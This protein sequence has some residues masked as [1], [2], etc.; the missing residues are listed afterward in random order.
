[1]TTENI[2]YEI[3]ISYSRQD[4][5]LPANASTDATAWVTAL[6]DHILA[7]HRGFSTE[8]LRIFFDTDEIRNMDDWRHR[9]L[10][11]LRSSKILLVCLSPNYFASDYCRWEWEEYCRRQVHQLIGSDSIAG[12]YFVEVPGSAEYDYAAWLSSILRGN[13]TDIRPWFPEGTSALRREEVRRRMAAL[14]QSVWERLKRAR[15]AIAVPGNLR[16]QNPHFVGRREELRRLHEQLGTGA[17][18]VVT[19][20]HGLGGQGKTELAVAYAHG[21]ADHYPAGLWTLG[22]E[23]KKE[24]LPLIGELAAEPQ[25]GF[26]PSAAEK[27]DPALLGCGVLVHLQQRVEAVNA[28]DPDKG[29]AALLLLDNVSESALLSPAQLATLPRADW[30][31]L[32][33]T[34]RLGPETLRAH[35]SQLA[36]LAVDSLDEDSALALLRNH[37]PPRDAR[38][39]IVA[40]S[41]VGITG[42]ASRN[43]DNAAREIARALGGFT[44]AIEQV[45]VFL[46]LHPEIAPSAFLAGL[47]QKGLTSADRLVERDLDVGGQLLTQTKQLAIILE[48]TLSRLDVPALTALQFAAL[49]PPDS[50]SWPWLRALTIMRHPAVTDHAPDE[51]DPWLEIRRRLSGLRLLTPGDEPELARIHRLVAAHVRARED[52][53]MQD[54]LLSELRAFLR[55][56]IRGESASPAVDWEYPVLINPDEEMDFI[57][58]TII[59]RVSSNP[60]IN[61]WMADITV[62]YSIPDPPFDIWLREF[63]ARE[64]LKLADTDPRACFGSLLLLAKCFR[65]YGLCSITA[66]RARFRAEVEFRTIDDVFGCVCEH[67]TKHPEVYAWSD[68]SDIIKNFE[69]VAQD[70]THIS[71]RDWAVVFSKLRPNQ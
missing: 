14:G 38:G 27:K 65:K 45:A 40:D 7:N 56:L 1:M 2:P 42:F 23:G 36:L 55:Y 39:S 20:V 15:R 3:F 24:L 6:R 21:W 19:A 71:S 10:G 58:E 50:V 26:K 46:G 66:S 11:A 12:V 35:Q 59:S 17:V 33:A 64:R 18:G 34:T 53:S 41:V 70:T 49:L 47:R 37:Q 54:S 43:E 25:L 69:Q 61:A 57:T 22:A 28:R 29:A 31:R 13:Y 62:D 67:V 30:L 68:F 60:E 8:P 44:L 32:M 52:G 4:N 9:I 63:A 48:A 5:R 16:R 51:P